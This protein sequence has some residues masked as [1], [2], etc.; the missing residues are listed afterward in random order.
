M[1]KFLDRQKEPPPSCI[2][3]KAGG[4]GVKLALVTEDARGAGEDTVKGE[5]ALG[6]Y[7]GVTAQGDR[8][9]E[10]DGTVKE[11]PSVRRAD[12]ENISHLGAVR[13]GEQDRIP[14][15]TQKGKHGA[16]ARPEAEAAAGRQHRLDHGP[17][18][19]DRS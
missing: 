16:A 18:L 10:R 5:G 6:L 19:G 9:S 12:E 3:A 7:E 11:K 15:L 17:Q 1:Q 13:G 2:A 8:L 4:A 14:P